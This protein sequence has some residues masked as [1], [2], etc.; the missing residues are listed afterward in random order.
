MW[1]HMSCSP[2]VLFFGAVGQM[3]LAVMV[4]FLSICFGFWKSLCAANTRT[5]TN[6]ARA[7]RAVRGEVR[8]SVAL[9]HLVAGGRRAAL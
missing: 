4:G 2:H 9:C 8:L 7:A 6:F 3:N 5:S 1:R